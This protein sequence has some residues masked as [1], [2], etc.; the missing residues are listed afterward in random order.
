MKRAELN[1]TIKEGLTPVIK[2]SLLLIHHNPRLSLHTAGIQVPEEAVV[3]IKATVEG[4]QQTKTIIVTSPAI[5]ATFEDIP[6]AS[7]GTR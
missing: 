5:I 3:V 6:A 1:S 4:E 7:V 2:H